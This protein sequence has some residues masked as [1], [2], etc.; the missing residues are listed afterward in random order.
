M[1][2]M[3]L[4]PFKD[5]KRLISLPFLGESP[6]IG[7]DMRGMLEWLRFYWFK[8]EVWEA[9]KKG[10]VLL[11][12]IVLGELILFLAAPKK[13]EAVTCRFVIDMALLEV[14]V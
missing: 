5:E 10:Y 11:R 7:V 12:V 6:S 9:L 1:I 4:W 3:R 8:K 14:G 13:G 2:E